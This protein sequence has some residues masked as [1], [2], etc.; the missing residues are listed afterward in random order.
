[1][2]IRGIRTKTAQDDTPKGE[3]APG[4]P[5]LSK[6]V[7]AW[8]KLAEHIRVAVLALVRANDGAGD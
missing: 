2:P 6:I 5:D 1:M 3:I 8:P 7:V 4:D